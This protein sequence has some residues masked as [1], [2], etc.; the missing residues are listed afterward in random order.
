MITLKHID[1]SIFIFLEHI[2][3]QII[4]E[5]SN[6]PLIVFEMREL[7][8]IIPKKYEPELKSLLRTIEKMYNVAIKIE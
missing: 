4:R 1:D 7:K 2:D 5:L 8:F 6:L 3:I